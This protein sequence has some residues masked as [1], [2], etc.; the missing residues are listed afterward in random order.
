MDSLVKLLKESRAYFAQEAD[1]S[2]SLTEGLNMLKPQGDGYAK[3]P[4]KPFDFVG[5]D[6]D[7]ARKLLGREVKSSGRPRSITIG[8]LG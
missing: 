1:M 8:I 7:D 6:T 4:I 5:R 2:R 3:P